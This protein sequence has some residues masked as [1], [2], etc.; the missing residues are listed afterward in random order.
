M[1]LTGFDAIEYAERECLSLN[2]KADR[3]DEQV[4]GLSIAEAEAI[5]D[6][7]PGLIWLD[8]PD[9]EYY[10][11]PRNMEPGTQPV[12]APRRAGQRRDEL[13]PGQA[14]S[15][16]GGNR[17]TRGTEGGTGETGDSGDNAADTIADIAELE[18]PLAEGFDIPPGESLTEP[19]AGHAGGAV[20]GTPAG[21]RVKPK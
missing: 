15:L 12:R 1:R 7:E 2:K 6:D 17:G 21:K 5:A 19:Q 3:I 8:V 9:E 14:S 10:G 16:G 18:D 20:G 4:L 13:A 11:G